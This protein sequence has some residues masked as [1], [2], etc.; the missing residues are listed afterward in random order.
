MVDYVED[1]PVKNFP[2]KFKWQTGVWFD[3]FE[4]QIG[5]IQTDIKRA[6][7]GERLVVYLSCPLSARGGGHPDTNVEIAKYTQ[8]RIMKK[9][10]TRFWVLNPAQYQMQSKEGSGLIRS[11][12]LKLYKDSE[13]NYRELQK[14]HSPEG[15]D[16][17]RMWTRVLVEDDNK[18]LGDHFSAYYFLGPS[19]VL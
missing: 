18:N 12:F 2:M 10:G 19:D 4:Q 15:G 17:M 1:Y 13:M 7:I 8:Q 11:H 9:W 5:L 14:E 16:Y 6:L 3:L